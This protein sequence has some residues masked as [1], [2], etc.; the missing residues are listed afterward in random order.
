MRLRLII[1]IR[2]G[3]NALLDPK[4]NRQLLQHAIDPFFSDCVVHR[5]GKRLPR[6]HSKARSRI[7]IHLSLLHR[8]NHKML[9]R[10]LFKLFDFLVHFDKILRQH[11]SFKFFE[12]LVLYEF[13]QHFIRYLQLLEYIRDH[14]IQMPSNYG[15]GVLYHIS[16]IRIR[17][18]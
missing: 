3:G 4:S 5:R 17:L 14:L 10:L 12:K 18:H 8:T 6:P 1:R 2:P 16:K 7:A 15:M 11:R 13:L 9:Q